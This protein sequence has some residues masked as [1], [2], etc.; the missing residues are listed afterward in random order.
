MEN[1]G[2]SKMQNRNGVSNPAFDTS[3][4]LS[5]EDKN[6]RNVLDA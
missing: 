6:K 5:L 2:D 3:G 1:Q 4:E